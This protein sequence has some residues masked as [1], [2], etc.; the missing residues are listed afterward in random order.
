MESSDGAGAHRLDPI[1]WRRL[2]KDAWPSE[3]HFLGSSELGLLP[4]CPAAMTIKL[5]TLPHQ[6]WALICDDTRT[7]HP[8][9]MGMG[10][11]GL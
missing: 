6:F 8:T 4:A 3:L 5:T 1:P 10:S 11:E 2:Q 9:R 7:T